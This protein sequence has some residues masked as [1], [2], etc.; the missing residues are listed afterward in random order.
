MVWKR[1]PLSIELSCEKVFVQKP[2]Y[3]HKKPPGDETCVYAGDFHF[4][5]LCFINGRDHFKMQSNYMG[6]I[7]R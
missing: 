7:R 3:T 2:E 4:N 6:A 1:N 5:M